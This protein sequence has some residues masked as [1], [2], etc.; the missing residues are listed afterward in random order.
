MAIRTQRKNVKK[1]RGSNH[2]AISKRRHK[3]ILPTLPW[4]KDELAAKEGP[5]PAKS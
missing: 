5:L 3:N 4:R 1:E 2:G